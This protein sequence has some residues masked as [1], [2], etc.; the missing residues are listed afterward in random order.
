MSAHFQKTSRT[1]PDQSSPRRPCIRSRGTAA[2]CLA[3]FVLL[4]S[5]AHAQTAYDLT[6]VDAFAT[7]T[8]RETQMWGIND[9]GVGCGN[10]DVVTMSNGNT[11]ITTGGY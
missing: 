7:T 2:A 10:T 3:A 5:P 8:T 11:S 6:I 1:T 4:T 9:L